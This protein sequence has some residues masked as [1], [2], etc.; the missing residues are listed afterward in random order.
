MGIAAKAHWA[1]ETDVDLDRLAVL[2]GV[3]VRDGNGI[4]SPYLGRD[5][6]LAVVTMDYTIGEDVPLAPGAMN[7]AK[8]FRY[9][10]GLSGAVSGLER[11]RREKRASHLSQYPMEQVTRVDRPTTLILDD[12]VPRV[13]KRALFFRRAAH[14]DLGPKAQREVKRF[15]LKHPLAAG[16]TG[17]LAS[18]VPYPGRPGRGTRSRRITPIPPPMRGPSS[19]WPISSARI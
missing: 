12:E 3:A 1:G 9:R 8:G 19:R 5:F 14:G 6:A 2:A 15:A 11:R 16:F 18:M 7:D 13:P 10:F 4:A 17:P